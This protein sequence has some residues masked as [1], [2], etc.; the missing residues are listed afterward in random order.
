MGRCDSEG[1]VA[2]P[3]EGPGHQRH[4]SVGGKRGRHSPQAFI[5]NTRCRPEGQGA[6]AVALPDGQ[7]LRRGQS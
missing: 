1:A 5:Q 3:Q 6:E 7:S 4:G 2:Y